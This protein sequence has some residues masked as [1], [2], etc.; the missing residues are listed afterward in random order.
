MPQPQ[1]PAGSPTGSPPGQPALAG[2]RVVDLSSGIAAAYCTKLFVDG[3]ADVVTVE[4]PGGNALRRR[5]ASGRTLAAGQDGAL[6]RFLHTGKRSLTSEPGPATLSPAIDRLVANADLVVEDAAPSNA[7]GPLLAR[8]HPHLVVV[9]LSPFGLTGPWSDRVASDLTLQALSSSIAGRGEKDGSPVTAGGELTEWASGVT[10]AVAALVALRRS[11]VTGLGEHIDLAKLEVAITIF[12]GF[13][14]VSGQ[15]V[16]PGPPPY[17]VVEV[18]S[19]EP[20]KDGWIGFATLS[21]DQF[22][23]FATMID[24]PEWAHDPEISRIDVRVDRAAEL[25][26]LIAEWTTQHPVDDILERSARLRIPA[27][28]VGNGVTAPLIPHIAERGVFVEHPGSRYTQPRV[29]YRMSRTPQPPLRPS[30]MAGST[31]LSA[32][33]AEWGIGSAGRANHARRGL[34]RA[35][36][37]LPLRGIRVFDLTSFWAG[38]YA[39]QVLGFF[40]AEVI[41][42]ESIQRPDGTR[43]AT[44]YGIRGDQAWER[45]PLFQAVN[46]GKLAIT[47][48]LSRPRGQQIGRELL[49]HCD[50][51]IE[52]YSPRVVER[53][54]LLD[55]DRPDLITVRMPAWG[56]SGPWRDLPGFAQTMEQASGL[57]WV[58]GFPDAPPLIPRGPCDPIGAL[59][60]AFAVMAAIL[61]R[62]RTGLGQL[63]EV[64]LVE[65]ALNVA[66]EQ[67]VEYGDSGT[68]LGRHGNAHAGASPH[69]VYRTEGDGWVAIAVM[70]D[71]Q[72][73]R[74]RRAL[75]DPEWSCRPAF[76][77]VEGRI[78]DRR[79]LDDNLSRWCATRTAHQVVELLWPAGIPAA[80][81]VAPHQ[82]VSLPQAA[83]RHFFETVTHPV[84]GSLR[85]PAFA[86]RFA[87]R[88]RPY[89]SAHAPLLGQD[90]HAIL[91]DWLG[92]SDADID[93]L[94][95]DKI[96]GTRPA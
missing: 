47:L 70:D 15:M 40:G 61:E 53:F 1:P 12:N 39:S 7:I 35:D 20:A 37:D 68:L 34:P 59:H 54:G 2:R 45:A 46:T 5:T 9:S 89:H 29:P 50:V 28:P 88:N 18:P 6:F 10:A 25:R 74:L 43:L 27:A 76:D 38:P 52:N 56:L 36:H 93:T 64:P 16:A 21:S 4:P 84:V 66:A 77:T 42:V 90:N 63:V 82:V 41:K 13:R 8:A 79:S 14:A 55:P 51:L 96:I 57:A 44:S 48:D 94:E 30:P 31:D 22:A 71:E 91:S 81:L 11:D 69:G 72:W 80:A 24:R 73:R 26:Q 19:I 92:L 78:A 33:A 3:G 23:N 85:L 17:Q 67:F 75:D 49:A 60:G 62:D 58:T 95:R 83:S 86:A 32:V 87:S 65:S